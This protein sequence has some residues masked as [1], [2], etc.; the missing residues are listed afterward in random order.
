MMTRILSNQHG[1]TLMEMMIG[2]TLGAM[3]AVAVYAVFVS[4]Q[5]SYYGTREASDAQGELRLVAGMMNSEFRAIGTNPTAGSAGGNF[6]FDPLG[7]ATEEVVQFRADL[8]GDGLID[9]WSEPAEVVLYVYS[10]DVGSLVRGTW[11]GWFEILSGV[12]AC[13]FSYF[14]ENGAQIGPPPLSADQLR[15]VQSIQLDM[16]VEGGDGEVR[17]WN[18]RVALRNGNSGT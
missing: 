9:G 6:Q 3:A 5:N 13:R 8:N 15:Q 17:T 2:L 1:L 10:P 14:D 16:A 12:D 11:S 7:I 18:S 4:T